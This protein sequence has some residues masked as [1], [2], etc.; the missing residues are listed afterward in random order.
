MYE[1][2][3][4]LRAPGAHVIKL[5][6]LR[7]RFGEPEAYAAQCS[8]GWTGEMRHGRTA[9]RDARQDGRRHEDDVRTAARGGR[10]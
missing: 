10:P 7:R 9:H 1:E 6:D 5:R 3:V 2:P 8:C 4:S